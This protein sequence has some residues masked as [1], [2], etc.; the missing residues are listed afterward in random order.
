MGGLSASGPLQ[1]ICVGAASRAAP[2]GPAR[3]AGPTQQLSCNEPL[4]SVSQFLFEEPERHGDLDHGQEVDRQLLESGGQPPSLLEPADQPLDHVPPLISRFVKTHT[5]LVLESG[6]DRPQPTRPQPAADALVVVRLVASHPAW[7]PPGRPAPLRDGHRI[8]HRLEDRRFV[9]L[10]GGQ[11]HPQRLPASIAHDMDLA[12]E[13]SLGA[14][15]GMVNRLRRRPA[16]FFR[17]RRRPGWPAP[18]SYRR[19]TDPNRCHR[20]L[21]LW[22]ARRS[23]GGPTVRFCASG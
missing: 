23:G 1:L 3:L 8:H 4:G 13:A 7:T 20:R 17:P 16:F 18:G 11:H 21:E 9:P 19:R 10:A 15:Q 22:P 6:D 5:P 2:C 12:T 14:A